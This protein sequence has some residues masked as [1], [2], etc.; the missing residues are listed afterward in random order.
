MSSGTRETLL[1]F[2]RGFVYPTVWSRIDNDGKNLNSH[3]PLEIL[4]MYI[5]PKV[6]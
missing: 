3:Q 2:S 4:G 1:D 6:E 5:H